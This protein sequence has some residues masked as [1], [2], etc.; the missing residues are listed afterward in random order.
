MEDEDL[1]NLEDFQDQEAPVPTPNETEK[2]EEAKTPEIKKLEEEPKEISTNE[3]MDK[4]EIKQIEMLDNLFLKD[5]HWCFKFKCLVSKG[6]YIRSLIR[7]ICDKLG[8]CGTMLNLIRTKQGK[9]NIDDCVSIDD[10]GEDSIKDI[11]LYLELPSVEVDEY[12]YHK[13][14]NG[15]ILENKYGASKIMF[16]YNN[17]LIAIYEEYQKDKN[18]IKPYCMLG[19]KK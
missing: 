10:V 11:K 8:I 17:E 6:T 4:N 14:I 18:K 2:E 1:Y 5:N 7:D 19:V 9:F 16:I 12:L 3:N 13:I 15:Q